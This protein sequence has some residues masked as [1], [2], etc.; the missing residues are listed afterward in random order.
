MICLKLLKLLFWT[1]ST[2]DLALMFISLVML[3][4]Y[5]FNFLQALVCCKM[6]RKLEA[7][8]CLCKANI[9]LYCSGMVKHGSTWPA[10]NILN[11][12]VKSSVSSTEV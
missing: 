3:L 1:V 12:Q 2:T 7:F 6:E 5:V 9:F 8:S 4:A 10:F 11:A